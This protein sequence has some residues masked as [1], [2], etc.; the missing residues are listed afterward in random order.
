MATALGFFCSGSPASVKLLSG[1]RVGGLY[2]TIGKGKKAQT[3]M[4]FG[5]A[6]AVTLD[7]AVSGNGRGK[8]SFG[9]GGGGGTSSW[10]DPEN[11]LVAVRML[12]Q[13]M[14]RE[15]CGPITLSILSIPANLRTRK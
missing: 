7:P 15:Q 12:Q 14:W 9:W 2:S 3:G 10:A 4:G 6:V 8:G 5:Y 13:E 1:D 11:D